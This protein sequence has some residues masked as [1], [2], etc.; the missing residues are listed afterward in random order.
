LNFS[1]EKGS[2]CVDPM[3]VKVSNSSWLSLSRL[4]SKKGNS[5]VNKFLCRDLGSL[6]SFWIRRSAEFILL[7]MFFLEVDALGLLGAQ[8]ICRVIDVPGL[9]KDEVY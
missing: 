2:L 1:K 8:S 7:K 9:H 6:G 5:F 4:W 3:A